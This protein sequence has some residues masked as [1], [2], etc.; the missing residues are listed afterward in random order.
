[1]FVWAIVICNNFFI[2]KHPLDLSFNLHFAQNCIYSFINIKP[3]LQCNAFLTDKLKYLN[4]NQQ[5]N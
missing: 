2:N 1:M 3:D 5:H 4:Y